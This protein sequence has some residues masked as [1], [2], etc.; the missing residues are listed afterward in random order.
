MC[1]TL[2]AGALLS[3]AEPVGTGFSVVLVD[4]IDSPRR[5]AAA[6]LDD[7]HR[8]DLMVVESGS[9]GSRLQVLLNHGTQFTPGWTTTY[10]VGSSSHFDID[11]ADTDNDLDNDVVFV[12]W[13]GGA[14]QRFN[15]GHGNFDAVGSVPTASVRF[16][17]ELRDMNGDNSVDLVYYEPDFFF[18]TYFGTQVGYGDGTFHFVA[19][20]EI[21]LLAD[22]EGHRR[23]ALGDIT[24]DGLID[25]VFTSVI[26]GG[27]RVFEG[28]PP[29]PLGQMP[30]WKQPQLVFE[31][32]CDDAVVADL[33]GDGRLDIIASS[34][35]LDSCVVFLTQ[36]N[37]A[38][39]PPRLYAAGQGPDAIAAADFDLDGRLDVLVA[40][41]ATGTVHV[42]R[43]TEA[44]GLSAPRSV[45]VGQSP[46]DVAT[47]DF[48]NDGDVDAAVA[49]AG[50]VAVLF[51]HALSPTVHF[52]QK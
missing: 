17:N 47:A 24:G 25:G 43:G 23:I 2:I 30:G 32:P 11:L 36:P 18:D 37:G 42:L 4:T 41:P 1:L 38:V 39:G 21:Q 27:I 15:D 26:T 28:K 48:D 51:N 46:L 7:N 34:Y 5:L 45:A 20:N 9:G 14:G 16:E 12:A 50:H 3:I 49:C 35:I 52:T 13:L 29:P 31:P 44:G 40:N 8:V 19:G 10:A 22:L 33:D 6:R